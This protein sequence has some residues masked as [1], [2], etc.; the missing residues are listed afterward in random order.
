MNNGINKLFV[1][2][3]CA[4]ALGT[5]CPGPVAAA[6]EDVIKAGDQVEIHYTCRL[7]NG[8]I[9]AT[10][11]QSVAD[12]ASLKKSNIFDPHHE[13]GGIEMAAGG[14]PGDTPGTSPRNYKDFEA[15]VVNELLAAVVGRTP[16]EFRNVELKIKPVSSKKPWEHD[17]HMALVR[18]RP[19]EMSVTPDVYKGHSGKAP[20]VGDSYMIDPAISGR[21]ESVTPLEVKVKFQ[22]KPGTVVETPFGKGTIRDGG[23]N[24]EIAIDVHE[25]QL[26]RTGPL[27]GRIS[28]ILNSDFIVDYGTPFKDEQLQCDFSVKRVK[29]E[30]AAEQKDSSDKEAHRQ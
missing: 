25:G 8:E 23:D 10:T 7:K 30:P 27:V 12:D 5:A 16:G 3:A 22:A 28:K 1:I 4:A 19:K 15:Q 6:P 18:K 17:L 20:Q 13:R 2:A 29:S 24:W 26:V 21:V 11:E 9:I 14:T